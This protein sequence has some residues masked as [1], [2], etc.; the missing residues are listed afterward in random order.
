[1]LCVNRL[2]GSASTIGLAV[3]L[4]AY[5]MS[6]AIDFPEVESGLH[7]RDCSLSASLQLSPTRCSIEYEVS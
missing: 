5:G 4:V 7:S 6:T 3:L 1:M 2:V